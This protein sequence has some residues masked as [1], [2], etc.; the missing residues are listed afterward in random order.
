MKLKNFIKQLKNIDKKNG[1]SMEVI[2]ADGIPV[3]E[4]VL[5]LDRYGKTSVV[6]T[7]QK[8]NKE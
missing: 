4:P 3:V 6:I 5:S 7:D 8:T 2:M 1:N